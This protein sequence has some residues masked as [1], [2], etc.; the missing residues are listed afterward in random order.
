LTYQFKAKT[1][2]AQKLV[3]DLVEQFNLNTDQER[4]FRI[5]ANHAVGPKAEQLKMYCT[6]SINS[7]PCVMCDSIGEFTNSPGA[8]C[9]M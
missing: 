3:D 8:R 2:A 1:E 7:P 6:K 9:D 4:A 5:V